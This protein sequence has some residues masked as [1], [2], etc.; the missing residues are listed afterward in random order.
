M[1]YGIVAPIKYE[2]PFFFILI[3]LIYLPHFI[4]E[5]PDIFDGSTIIYYCIRWIAI[6]LSFPIVIAYLLTWIIWKSQSRILKYLILSATI[7][8]AIITLFLY[9]NFN[10]ILS[11]W[12]LLLL[13]ETNS[14]ESSEFISVYLFSSGTIYSFLITLLPLILTIILKQ[15]IKQPLLQRKWQKIIVGCLL[16]AFAPVGLY[17]FGK[18]AKLFLLDTQYDIEEWRENQGGYAMNNTLTNLVYSVRYL[19]LSGKDNEKAIACCVQASKMPATCQ[20]KDSLNIIFIIGESFSKHHASVYGYYLNTTP[21]M[22]EEQQKGNLFVF[23]DVV[24]PF[25][26]TTFS[27]KNIISTNIL[28]DNET[29]FSKPAF[30]ILFKKAGYH[31]TMWDNQRPDTDVSTYDYALGSYLYAKEIVPLSYSVYNTKTFKYDYQMISHFE[32]H[33]KNRKHNLNI[34]HLMGQHSY[35]G[36]RFP[37]DEKLKIFKANDIKRDDLEEWQKQIIADYDNATLY[38]DKVVKKIIDIFRKKCTVLVYLSDHGEELF[39]YRNFIGRTHEEKKSWQS[40]KYQYEIPFVVWCSNKF[41]ETYP[42]KVAAID[43][44]AKKSFLSSNV[45]QMLL[46][47]A[48]IDTPFYQVKKDVL[49]NTYQCGKRVLQNN[50]DYDEIMK[51]KYY[52]K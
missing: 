7:I 45:A 17:M 23:S 31:V 22:V 37:D 11:P 15:K 48:S 9:F 5:V 34:F 38:N 13:K 39:D 36:E 44:A 14:T 42:E 32:Y 33:H 19:H 6:T 35:A 40:L 46:S 27:V 2:A 21:T 12:I 52:K 1:I 3:W 25:N 43:N 47:L 4:Y 10:T 28:E 26:M 41:K 8:L 18:T 24:S 49:S 50:N 51:Q 29:W 16:F 30:P 20:N